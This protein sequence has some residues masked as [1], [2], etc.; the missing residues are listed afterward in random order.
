MTDKFRK[1]KYITQIPNKNGWSFRVRYKNISKV[2]NE[3]DY[4]SASQCFKSAIAYRNKILVEPIFATGK[5]VQDCFDELEYFYITRSETRRKHKNMFDLYINHKNTPID[6]VTR[7]DIQSDLNNMVESCSADL[8]G[9]VLS[10]WR[11][12]FELAIAKDYVG[13]DVSASVKTPASMKVMK[14]KRMELTDEETLTKLIDR[15]QKRLTSPLMKAQCENILWI[16]FYT[17]M[18][19]AELL[20]LDKSDVDLKNRTISITKEMGSDREKRNVVRTVKTEMSRR[21]IPI[22]DKCLPYVQSAMENDSPILFPSEEGEHYSNI[23][24]GPLFHFHAKKI[25]IDFHLYQCR[26]SFITRLFMQGVD[27]KTIQE[28]CGQT[29]DA[30]TIGYVV[31][32]EERRVRAV[33]L[34]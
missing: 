32:D 18:R 7:A 14:N 24:V 6:K 5:T 27:L 10:L 30:T 16:L 34:M 29:I 31:S 4:L 11:K 17:G 3:A 9:R 26:H 12:I 15:L 25:G 22:S 33:N 21:T 23:D 19:P 2:F 20:A 8:I 1:E 13:K 28:L